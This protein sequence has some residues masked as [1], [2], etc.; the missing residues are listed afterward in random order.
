MNIKEAYDALSST[1]CDIVNIAK[2]KGLIAESK[3]TVTDR[4]LVTLRDEADYEQLAALVCGEVTVSANGCDEKI[5]LECAVSINEGSVFSDEMVN[6]IRI[7]RDNLSA[8]CDKIDEENVSES[9]AALCK[10][11][12][13]EEDKP[14]PVRS[15]KA[16]YIGALCVVGIIALFAIAFAV[17]F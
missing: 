11:E 12:S 17:I 3:C 8:L 5:V 9:F 4:D 14:E 13:H 15:N 7:L 1:L 16:F 2:E 6:E 10:E